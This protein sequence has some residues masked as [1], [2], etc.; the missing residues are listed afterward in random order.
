MGFAETFAE[1]P[2]E[3]TLI[4][5]WFW[6]DDLT[7]DELRRQMDDFRDHGVYGF[8]IHPRIGLPESIGFMSPRFLEL[9]RFAVDYAA[10]HDMAVILYDEGMYPSGSCAGEV[11]A[12]NLRY[13]SRCLQRRPQGTDLGDL[14]ELVGEDA[15]WAYVHTRSMGVIRGVHFGQDDGDPGAPPAGDLLNP[16]A[17]ATFRHLVL[18]RYYEA[19]K[20]HFGK[21][22]WAVFTD[23]PSFLAKRHLPDVQPWTWGFAEYLEQ[24]LGY[25]FRPHL[26]ALWDDAHRDAEVYRRHYRAALTSR[27]HETFYAPYSQWCADHGVMLTGH[28]SGGDDIGALRFFQLP[29]QDVVWRYLE[30]NT[31]K[32]LEGEQSTMGKCG[33]S[34][35]RHYGRKRNGNECFGAYGWN[36]T[37]EEM[38]WVTDWLLVRGVNLLLPHAFYYS[39]RDARRDERPPDVGPNNVWWNE[40]RGYSDYCRRLCWML[41]QGTH[42]CDVAI[43]GSEDSLPWRAAKVLFQNQRDF[44]YL[45]V[46]TLLHETV[47]DG[48]AA[49]VAGMAYQIVV[50]DG[51]QYVD[52]AV[53]GKLQPLIDAGR[54]VAYAEPVPELPL[55]AP[56][57]KR[58]V[59]MLEERAPADV[60]LTPGHPDVRYIHM[61]H[62][63]GDV[64]FFF[65]E[66][67]GNVDVALRVTAAGQCQWWSGETGKPTPDCRPDRLSLGRYETRVL[68]VT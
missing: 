25:D 34:A 16:E 35:Q 51:P 3:Y 67:P 43:L 17:M 57:D 7:E 39:V 45:D 15:D 2:R 4:P 54:V 64:Y 32:A 9:C 49:R 13:A 18:D 6:N 23:E 38:R 33:S 47:V 66:G 28:P 22:V 1:P 58:L 36:F 60:R 61:R 8:V 21:T 42:V 20:D 11:V 10:E 55:L 46:A 31:P 40:Y 24:Q 29:G 14:E 59:A 5:F 48:A 37:Y 52:H 68:R 27:L 63:D 50:V 53:L 30:P 62:E 65:N 12:G 41:A 56:D 44:N 19:L 26:A